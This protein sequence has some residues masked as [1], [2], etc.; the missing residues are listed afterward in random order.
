MKNNSE[1]EIYDKLKSSKRI[2]LSLHAG[3]D[4]DSLGGCTSLKYFLERDFDAEVTLVSYD[5]LDESLSKIDFSN[6]VEFGKDIL[7]FDLK[8][9]DILIA[10]DCGIPDMIGKLKSNKDFLKEIFTINIDHH[11]ANDSYGNLNL[12]DEKSP[13]AC[14]VLIDFLKKNKVKFDR[15]LAR[16]LLLGV[17]SD[18][19]YFTAFSDYNIVFRDVDFLISNDADYKKDVLEPVI[20]NK[21]LRIKKYFSYIID[22]FKVN[23]EKSFGYSIIPLRVIDELGLNLSEVR[24]G[25]NEINDIAGLDF[26]FTLTETKEYV[27]GSFRSKGDFDVSRLAQKL[28]TDGGGH[29][30]A[31]A[32]RLKMSLSEA[33][34][35]V[36][37]VISDN[38]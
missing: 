34:K 36:L 8:N 17:C 4:G 37:K 28:G 25:V 15:E 21:P 29:K 10:F 22:N 7:D 3:P 32:F 6:E 1:K 35:E 11:N 13:S 5:K 23:K 14:S 9:F 33:E 24:L 27:K 31:A 12:V 38:L 26:V 2:L 20:L 18:A 16:R 19:V 30:N